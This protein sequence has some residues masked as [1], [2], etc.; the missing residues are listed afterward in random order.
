MTSPVVSFSRA[1]SLPG[2]GSQMTRMHRLFG[3]ALQRGCS[4]G[5]ILLQIEGFWEGS[6]VKRMMG[7]IIAIVYC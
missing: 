3:R 7:T 4:S 6:P 2:N 5:Q 1:I